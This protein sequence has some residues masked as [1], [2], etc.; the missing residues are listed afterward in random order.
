MGSDNAYFGADAGFFGAGNENA[1]FGRGAGKATFTNNRTTLIGAQAGVVD[2]AIN[3]TAIGAHAFA[4]ATDTLVLGS[5]NGTNGATSEPNVG[6]GTTTPQTKFQVA[7]GDVY[8][9]LAGRGLILKSFTGL[10]CT[11]VRVDDSHQLFLSNVP[12][13]GG[14][15]AN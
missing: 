1:Y 9:S 13:P 11:L 14:I 5:V 3:A 8:I 10:S 4:G 2:G 6:I 15:V 12:C 7:N